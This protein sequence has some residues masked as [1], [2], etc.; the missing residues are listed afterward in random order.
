[1]LRNGSSPKV[2]V[3]SPT[4]DVV[5]AYSFKPPTADAGASSMFYSSGH[6]AFGY[7]LIELKD[8]PSDL[9]I[10]VID[11]EDGRVLCGYVPAKD[12][13]GLPACYKGQDFT[14]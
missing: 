10:R 4:G 3:L 11:A 6:L 14:L 8:C 13:V 9:V 2:Y 7:S 5:R 1:M 12:V